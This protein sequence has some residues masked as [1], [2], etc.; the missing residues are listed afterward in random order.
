MCYHYDAAGNNKAQERFGFLKKSPIY[1]PLL[2]A[3]GFSHPK[4][5]VVTC[6]N[7][8][9]IELYE[10]GLLPTW[11]DATRAQDFSNSTLN[12]KAETMFELS[13][14]REAAKTRCLV[15]ASQFYEWRTE[16]K[17]KIPYK[18]GLQSH[19]VF[20]MGGIFT[21]YQNPVTGEKK[22]T[23]S[24]VTIPA[25]NI[26]AYV[27]NVKKRMPFIL[28]DEQLDTW[29]NPNTTQST[30]AQ[31]MKPIKSNDMKAEVIKHE[32]FQYSLF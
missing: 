2:N 30:I 4:M 28:S 7:P 25:N 20:P 6:H 15:L 16:G 14:F 29:L 21:L 11:V 31:L 1:T 18:I 10:W 27:H 23:F 32:G 5:P 8:S 3:N 9:E 19:E 13:S 17:T 24:I 26:M 22:G 12:A